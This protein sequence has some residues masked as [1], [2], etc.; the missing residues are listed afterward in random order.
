MPGASGWGQGGGGDCLGLTPTPPI[1]TAGVPAH[2]HTPPPARDKMGGSTQTHNTRLCV[3]TSVPPPPPP[4]PHKSAPRPWPCARRQAVAPH[5]TPALAPPELGGRRDG[6]TGL[7]PWGP[8]T[9]QCPAACPHVRG[10]LPGGEAVA[11]GGG[12]PRVVRGCGMWLL[13]SWTLLG[14]KGEAAA[15][16]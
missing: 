2:R 12:I 3:V 10:A 1:P 5:S 9:G 6:G 8:A 4:V 14:R 7:R 16:G 15:F 13:L 11:P